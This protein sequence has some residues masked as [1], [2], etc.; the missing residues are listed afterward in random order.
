MS[1]VF[2]TKGKNEGKMSRKIWL[3]S[4]LFQGLTEQEADKIT[5]C[6]HGERRTFDHEE[7]IYRAGDAGIRLGLILAGSVNITKDDIWGNHKIID[8]IGQ[9]QIFGEA[10]ECIKGEALFVNVQAVGKTE[11]MFLDMC[12]ML[13]TCQASCLF[14]QK[15]IQNLFFLMADRNLKL[16]RKMDYLTP[17]SIRER[18]LAYLSD[19]VVKNGQYT[20]EIPFNRQQM[21]DYLSV[22]RSALSNELSKM[23][24]DGLIDFYKNSFSVK[25]NYQAALPD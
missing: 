14:H 19:Q 8:N 3:Q 23:K 21:A 6:L 15:L 25:I 4:K 5:G 17:K 11:V 9:G 12:R 1:V 22:D 10:Y 24:Q 7:Y 18:I 2:T 20:F 13:A 16:M